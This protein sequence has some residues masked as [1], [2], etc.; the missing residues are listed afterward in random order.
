MRNLLIKLPGVRMGKFT[1]L[2]T[3]FLMKS[4]VFH[5]TRALGLVAIA[6]ANIGA[7]DVGK[8]L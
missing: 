3:S 1:A 8:I 4:R 6:L 2:A 7:P 5:V